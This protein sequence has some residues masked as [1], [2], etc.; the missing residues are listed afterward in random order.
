M[1]SSWAMKVVVES[2]TP[3]SIERIPRL[4]YG[5]ELLMTSSLMQVCVDLVYIYMCYCSGF[6][7]FELQ[8]L[9]SINGF[10][11]VVIGD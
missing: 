8:Y 7:F 6:L 9:W 4:P 1:N 11:V 10:L 3:G 5:I 2:R